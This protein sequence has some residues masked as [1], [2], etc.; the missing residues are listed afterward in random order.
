[1]RP[2][3]VFDTATDHVALAIGDL[4]APGAVVAAEDFKAVRAANTVLLP[5]VDRLLGTSGLAPGDLAAVACG[6]GPG[7]FTGARIGVATA[8][9]LAHGLNVPLVGFGTLDAVAARTAVAGAAAQATADAASAPPGGLLGVLGD[10]M[11]GEVYPALFRL[12]SG[13]VERLTGD[14]VAFP[15]EVAAE[16]ADLDEPIYLSGNAFGKHAAVF[17]RALGARARIVDER[18]WVPDGPSLV[19]AAWSAE[20]PLTLAAIASLSGKEALAVAYPAILQPIYTR[21]SDAEEAERAGA[22]RRPVPETGVAGA[23]PRAGPAGPE[24]ESRR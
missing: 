14:R 5:A 21:L 6:R 7:S 24:P 9:G 13:A 3:C 10:A 12:A 18:H 20:G 16:W 2:F 15:E 19:D 4:D 23:L 1:V 22:R 11:R 17:E 8:K